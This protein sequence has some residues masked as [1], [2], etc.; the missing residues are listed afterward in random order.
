MA[1]DFKAHAHPFA[2]EPHALRNS[3]DSNNKI[4]LELTGDKSRQVKSMEAG[5][6]ETRPKNVAVYYYVRIN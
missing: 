6:A 3:E 4:D 1:D 2:Y 5:G